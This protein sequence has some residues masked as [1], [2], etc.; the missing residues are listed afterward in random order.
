V[1]I[2]V[3]RPARR[4]PAAP[5]WVAALVGTHRYFAATLERLLIRVRLKRRRR[6]LAAFLV[7]FLSHV[8]RQFAGV[9]EVMFLYPG[10]AKMGEEEPALCL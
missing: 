4:D 6:D 2:D 7:I 5:H 8:L 9:I 10:G 3:N 1:R